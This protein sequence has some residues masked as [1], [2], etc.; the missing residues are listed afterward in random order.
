MEIPQRVKDF[1]YYLDI[2]HPLT[3]DELDAIIKRMKQV[4]H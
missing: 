3:S 2:P 4:L 1:C